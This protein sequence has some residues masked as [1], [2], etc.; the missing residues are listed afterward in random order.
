MNQVSL[1]DSRPT[2]E[3]EA[4]PSDG[5]LLA[6]DELRPI[7]GAI[8]PELNIQGDKFQLKGCMGYSSVYY[9]SALVMRLRYG[10]KPTTSPSRK[11]GWKIF[12]TAPNGRKRNRT[13][14]GCACLLPITWGRSWDV[15]APP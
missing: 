12:R 2:D 14:G 1:F 4:R 5:E 11:A 7:I 13:P 9:G 10:G 15:W 3:Q 6:Y 8:C